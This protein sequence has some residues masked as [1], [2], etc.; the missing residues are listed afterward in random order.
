MPDIL[1]TFPFNPP[2]DVPTTNVTPPDDPDALSP[3]DMP[4]PFVDRPGSLYWEVGYSMTTIWDMGIRGSPLA[5]PA[6]AMTV[7]WRQNGVSAFRV[8]T[9]AVSCVG[10]TPQIPS[11]D[12]GDSGNS[13]LLAKMISVNVPSQFVDGNQLFYAAGQ[14]VWG[15][16]KAP[17]DDD[18]VI[19]PAMLIRADLTKRQLNP[20]DFLKYLIG[21][22]PTPTGYTG[23]FL[24]F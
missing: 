10:E 3:F 19:I 16:Q 9:W 22:L 13:V 11:W 7:F 18:P 21:P 1:S 23:S 14:Y 8:C 2:D 6:S 17:G 12:L 4:D 5:G 24:P 15:L 20:A